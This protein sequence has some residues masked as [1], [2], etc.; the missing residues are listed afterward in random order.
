MIRSHKFWGNCS[1]IAETAHA[2]F[3]TNH[4]KVYAQSSKLIVKAV[5]DQT[6]ISCEFS[7]V[8]YIFYAQMLKCKNCCH[9]DKDCPNGS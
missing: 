2:M 5:D 1:G 7:I 3:L 9:L 8:N 4:H 6:S